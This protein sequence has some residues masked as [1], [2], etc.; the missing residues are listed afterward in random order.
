MRDAWLSALLLVN[1][2]VEATPELSMNDLNW[3]DD[4]QSPTSNPKLAYMKV[5]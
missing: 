3:M 1:H 4:L 5:R 2:Y